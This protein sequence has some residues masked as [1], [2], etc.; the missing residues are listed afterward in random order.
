MA[1]CPRPLLSPKNRTR[2]TN[3]VGSLKP[4][5]SCIGR[6]RHQ[7]YWTLRFP[8]GKR[9]LQAWRNPRL[10][11]PFTIALS[12]WQG[13]RQPRHSRPRRQTSIQM[14]CFFH[15]GARHNGRRKM[16]LPTF[17]GRGFAYNQCQTRLADIGSLR[18]RT[19]D[20]DAHLKTGSGLAGVV[21]S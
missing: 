6:P 12:Y 2:A 21:R 1:L 5:T 4:Q 8:A 15:S 9:Y 13:P 3:T 14:Y 11:L 18:E 10:T 17:G 16:P 7:R 20:I 19:G